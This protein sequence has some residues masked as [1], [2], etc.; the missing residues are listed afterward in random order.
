MGGL[1]IPLEAV[2]ALLALLVLA[3]AG[4]VVRRRWLSR[5]FGTF[6]CSLRTTTGAHG[7]GWRLGV[8]RYEAD[9]I[10]WFRVFSA[11]MRPRHVLQRSDLAVQE[12][13]VPAGAE[14][15]SV[16]SG[17]L[18]VR[19]RRPQGPLELAMS[20]QSYTGFASWLESAPPGQNVSVA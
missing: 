16:M 3:I 15:F 5:Q 1:L 18:I 11:S 12:R 14:A 6:D 8:A 20:E 17:F 9:R 2:A 19:C 4:V 7:K 10:E 13:R